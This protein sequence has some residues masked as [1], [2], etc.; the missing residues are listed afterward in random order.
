MSKKADISGK[1]TINIYNRAWAEWVLQD[2]E[3]E[4]EAELSGEFQ[5]IGRASDSLLRVRGKDDKSFLSLTELQLRHETEMP[6]RTTAYAALARHKYNLEVY[7]TIIYLLPPPEGTMI[8]SSFHSDFM[9]QVGHQDFQVIKLWELD[10]EK[11]LAFN[12]PAIV[13][14][15]PLMAGGNTERMLHKCADRIRQ[16][17]RSLELETI[18]SVFASYVLDTELIK[19]ILR[20]E[21][22]V[23]KESPIL[24]E[25]FTEQYEQGEQKGEQKATLIAL[26]QTLTI[27]FKVNETYL[28]DHNF[29]LL[30][31]ETLREL[32]EV[33]LTVQT[34]TE[35]E[36]RLSD[37][38]S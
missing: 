16:E 21:M 24:Q 13:P 2:Q 7:V 30:D 18:L 6:Q 34:L 10:A 26:Y 8:A 36:D 19:R 9:G 23:I 31:S 22:Q 15:I 33:A 11:A 20:W 1:Q 25:A 27:R 28:T 12:N 38:S 14:F 37:I 4:V 3:I 35:F 5:F 32:N 17:P 29:E